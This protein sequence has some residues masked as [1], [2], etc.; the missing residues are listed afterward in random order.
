M[1]T[2]TTPS[3]SPE[4]AEPAEPAGS[5]PAAPSTAPP[6]PEAAP[7]PGHDQAPTPG[8]EAAPTPEYLVDPTRLRR[9]PRYGRIVTLGMLAGVLGAAVLTLFSPASALSQ[10][11]LFALLLI[12]SVPVGALAGAVVALVLDRRSLRRADQLRGVTRAHG[13][14]EP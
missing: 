14:R 2:P 10:G 1:S 3:G 11:N 7:T 8:P 12:T 9:A 5:G 6:G 13:T 4:P